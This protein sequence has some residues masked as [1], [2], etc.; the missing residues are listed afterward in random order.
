M[1]WMQRGLAPFPL[2]FW[3]L[4]LA[5]E[6][7]LRLASSWRPAT[8]LHNPRSPLQSE[9]VFAHDV[10][11]E[12]RTVVPAF[13]DVLLVRAAAQWYRSPP[14]LLASWGVLKPTAMTAVL[15]D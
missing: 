10:F 6:R 5:E 7:R 2:P 14:G 9:R 8:P 1:N 12:P 13:G 4:Q 3:I 11:D 15:T